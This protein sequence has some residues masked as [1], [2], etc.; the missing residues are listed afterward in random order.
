M[1]LEEMVMIGISDAEDEINKIIKAEKKDLFV[2]L[3]GKHVD[4]RMKCLDGK[5]LTY[6]IFI[7]DR[8]PGA[9]WLVERFVN[10]KPVY[11]FI[12]VLQNLPYIELEKI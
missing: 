10:V 8:H 12:N 3:I 9:D 7:C 11:E 5:P 4:E 6:Y 2:K 1:G